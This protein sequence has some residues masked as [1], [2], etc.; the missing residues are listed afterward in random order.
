MTPEHREL[1]SPTGEPDRI[2]T[3]VVALRA[4]CAERR[5]R[6]TGDGAVA[7]TDAAALLG[8]RPSTLRGWRGTHRPIPFIKA[9][10]GRVFYRLDAL[11]AF[12]AR[13][14]EIG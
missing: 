4:A 1:S 10:T 14:E 2:A 5:L 3:F 9:P 11:A 6:V 12:L 7:E 13:S 8:R